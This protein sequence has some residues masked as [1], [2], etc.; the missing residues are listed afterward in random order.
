MEKR[1]AAIWFRH[2]KTDWF[3]L[4]HPALK[5]IQLVLR[6]PD[7]GRM[8]VSAVNAMAQSQ[9]IYT[10]MT[11]AD[12]RA[13]TPKIEVVDDK[14]EIWNR[15]LTRIAEWCIRFSPVVAVDPP[16]GILLDVSGCTHLWGGDKPYL[17][18]IYKRFKNRGYDI[19]LAIADSPG[20]AWA[21]AR[22]G[23]DSPIITPGQNPDALRALPPEALRL[24][25]ETVERLYKLGLRTIQQFIHLPQQTLRRRFGA[26]CIMR[27]NQ[28]LGH[29]EEILSSVVPVPD[30]QE[31]LPCLEPIKTAN[32]IEV[33]LQKLL[34]TMCTR[35]QR[36]QKGLRKLCFKGYRMDGK[37]EQLD[38]STNSPSHHVAHL[39]KLFAIKLPTIEPDLG[40]ELFV[41]EASGI[42][43]H[44]AKQ[45]QQ[46]G[47]AGGLQDTRIA[48]MID[49]IAGRI[50][51]HNIIRYVPAEH[52]WPERSLQPAA[53]LDQ[54][55]TTAW[56][57]SKPRPVQLL[58]PPEP[59]TVTAPVPDYPPMSFR[60][61]GTLHTITKADG[62][63]RIEQEWWLQ[64]GQHRD[65]YAVEDKEGRRYWIFRLG[66][67]DD[68]FYQWF[69][70]GFF[71]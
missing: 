71:A 31:R 26:H 68:K 10:G 65:Y 21:V 46:W 56:Q 45:E 12:A 69:I 7:H 39:F 20:T 9:G 13:I 58:S 52:Y 19:R 1:F 41:L 33:A 14:P 35:L 32:A 5:N 54:P 17:T 27:I 61:K 30:Y 51:I 62:P 38:I 25:R 55:T 18:E 49:R 50:G 42:A 60:Y 4:Q 23:K 8:V 29:E 66:H 47:G 16:D 11:I 64:Q 43:D 59:I 37:I 15:L 53:T 22:F 70:H 67:Y 63:E 57:T 2:L 48:E 28:A 36:E 34:E 40:I 44:F 6:A 3:S 24:E